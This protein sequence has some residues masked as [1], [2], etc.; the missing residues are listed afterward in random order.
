MDLNKVKEN[1]CNL[2]EGMVIANYKEL[3]AILEIKPPTTTKQ[4]NYQI[5]KLKHF[6]DFETKGRKITIT[7][8]YNNVDVPKNI[9]RGNSIYSDVVDQLMFHYCLAYSQS[10]NAKIYSNQD[11]WYDFGMVNQNYITVGRN[12]NTKKEFLE[13]SNDITEYEIDDFYQRTKNKFY[14]IIKGCLNR[15]QNQACLLYEEK[16]QIKFKYIDNNGLEKYYV[17]DA[18]PYE[19]DIIVEVR[20]SVMNEVRNKYDNI[21]TINDIERNYSL[22]TYFYNEIRNRIKPYLDT[23]DMEVVAFYKYIDI[24]F[25]REEMIKQLR[26]SNINDEKLRLNQHMINSLTQQVDNRI[27]KTGCWDKEKEELLKN[28]DIEEDVFYY[29]ANYQESQAKLTDVLINLLQKVEDKKEEINK[30]EFDWYDLL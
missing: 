18:S 23:N 15:L 30:D 7:K 17:R 21:R 5:K 20:A 3:C 26:S 1:V 10:N 8:I 19:K 11:C 9:K 27:H 24:T 6:F 28:G 22:K 12:A 16:Y 4:K 2:S 29:P 25:S 14:K 13:K